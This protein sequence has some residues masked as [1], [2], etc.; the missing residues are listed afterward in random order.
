MNIT[1][2]QYLFAAYILYACALLGLFFAPVAGAAVAYVKRADCAG[3]AVLASHNEYL[4]RT[5]W[6]G[7]AATAIGLVLSLV[8]IGW[9]V[10]FAAGLWLVFRVVKGVIALNDNQPVD[11]K[12]W[13]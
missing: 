7:A 8:V 2:K 11:A 5:F 12:S 10:L 3:D 13:L 6:L 1:T 9:A 4:I